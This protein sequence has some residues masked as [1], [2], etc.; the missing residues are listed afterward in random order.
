MKEADR[1]D[2]GAVTGNK[3][4][5]GSG[6]SEERGGAAVYC[7]L[8]IFRRAASARTPVEEEPRVSA[9]CARTGINKGSARLWLAC[10]TLP[11]SFLCRL[12]SFLVISSISY[13]FKIKLEINIDLLTAENVP[14]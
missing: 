13:L 3:T 11:D 8:S 14:Q 12:T 6:L 1:L 7:G 5:S 2:R 4:P 9:P 10:V